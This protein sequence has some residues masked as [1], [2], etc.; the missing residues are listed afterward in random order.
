MN[1]INYIDKNIHGS[2]GIILD[3]VLAGIYTFIIL[4]L[5]FFFLGG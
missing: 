2:L 5:L 3:D 1:T 4:T